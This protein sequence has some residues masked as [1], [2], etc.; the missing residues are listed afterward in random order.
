MISGKQNDVTD[1][2]QAITMR[3][4][5]HENFQNPGDSTTAR[6]FFAG[7]GLKETT[8][9]Y[10]HV[11]P[12]NTHNGEQTRRVPKCNKYPIV[13]QSIYPVF[14]EAPK[15]FF[16]DLTMVQLDDFQCQPTPTKK[17]PTHLQ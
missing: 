13:N 10:V 9:K 16:C 7:G 15:I 17:I 3:K 11:L 12:S 1:S 6:F 14:Q 8:L 4:L 2:T 5:I